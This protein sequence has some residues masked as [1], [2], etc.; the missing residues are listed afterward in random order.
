MSDDKG[1]LLPLN[2]III[3]ESPT[4]TKKRPVERLP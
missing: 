2:T 4:Q 1:D 3:H